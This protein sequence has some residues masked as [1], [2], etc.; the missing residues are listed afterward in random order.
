MFVQFWFYNPMILSAGARQQ[1]D[2][3][4]RLASLKGATLRTRCSFEDLATNPYSSK[5]VL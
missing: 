3:N 1:V 4:S 5:E 2:G